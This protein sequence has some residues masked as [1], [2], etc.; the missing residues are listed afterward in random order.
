ME[1]PC[2]SGKNSKEGIMVLLACSANGTEKLPPL[3][4]GNSENPHCFKTV[5]K[6]PTKCIATRKQWVT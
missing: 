2:N 1:V 3:V 4:N 6:L 5:R